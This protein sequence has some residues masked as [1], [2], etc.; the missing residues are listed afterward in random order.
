M[1]NS[2]QPSR[3]TDTS[4]AVSEIIGAILLISLVVSAIMIVGVFLFS[5]QTPE[6]IPNINFMTGT[7][8][9]GNLYLYHNGG[10]TLKD[11]EFYVQV[12]GVSKPY[13]LL[14]GNEWS[15]GKSLIIKDVSPGAHTVQIILSPTREEYDNF[16]V[17][18]TC[19]P[20]NIAITNNG[21]GSLQKGK[22]SVYTDG[23]P[24]AFTLNSTYYSSGITLYISPFDSTCPPSDI[25]FYSVGSS[26]DLLL[27]TGSANISMSTAGISP[28]VP[29]SVTPSSCISNCTNCTDPVVLLQNVLQNVSVIGDAI[30]QSPETVGPVIANVVGANSISFYKDNRVNLAKTSANYFKFNVTKSGSSIS[31]TD[32][33]ATPVTLYPGDIVTV[34]FRSN[35]GIFKTFGLGDELWELSATGVD[36]NITHNG[37]PD[38]RYNGDILHTWITGYRDL[39]STMTIVSSSP[40]TSAT[41]LV[42]NGTQWINGQNSD[43]VQVTNIRPVGIGLFLLEGDNNA[44]IVYFVGNAQSVTRNGHPCTGIVCSA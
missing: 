12:D 32:F 40:Y 34:Y 23:T 43:N 7:D 37:T 26:G 18:V 41:A 28:D 24:R 35:T 29:P 9:L 19:N 5:Q 42:I 17:S 2:N 33:G 1:P 6:E 13:G 36:V 16:T 11:G 10:D 31:A 25:R 22:F 38:R 3:K 15:F 14:E 30:N 20:G 21:P 8:G 39:G 4:S 44:H 27:R